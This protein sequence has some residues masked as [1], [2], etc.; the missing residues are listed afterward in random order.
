MS[1]RKR[2]VSERS[3]D[4][5]DDHAVHA[6]GEEEPEEDNDAEEEE[7]NPLE[8]RETCLKK[9]SSQDFIMEPE[10]FAQLKTYFQV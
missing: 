10:I 9:F 5:D 7:E 2:T 3:D 4:D 1:T 6:H 8:V